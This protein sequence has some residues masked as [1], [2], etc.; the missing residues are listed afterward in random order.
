MCAHFASTGCCSE[1]GLVSVVQALVGA[2]VDTNQQNKV[3]ISL[4]IVYCIDLSL[5]LHVLVKHR[6]CCST[7]KIYAKSIYSVLCAL[8]KVDLFS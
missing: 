4:V 6:S 7:L 3:Q 8:C 1:R 2:H 5:F